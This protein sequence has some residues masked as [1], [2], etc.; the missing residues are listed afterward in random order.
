[1]SRKIP[2]YKQ[3]EEDDHDDDQDSDHDGDHDSDSD[4]EGSFEEASFD[5]NKALEGNDNDNKTGTQDN[6][7]PHSKVSNMLANTKEAYT[8]MIN[9]HTIYN[10][11]ANAL[12]PRIKFLNK[13]KT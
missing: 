9:R 7:Q 8:E 10:I 13:E 12:F 1:M 2:N 11:V 4:S 5:N 3:T 6:Q